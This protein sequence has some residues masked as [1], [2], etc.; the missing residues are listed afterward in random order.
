MKETIKKYLIIYHHEDNDGVFSA[1]IAETYIRMNND[2]PS[3]DNY[4]I[5][6]CPSDYVSLSKIT[7]K[8][9]D[10]WKKKY[11][12]VIMTDISFSDISKMSYMYHKFGNNFI[13]ID[14]HKPAIKASYKNK[15]DAA[16]GERDSN[17]SAILLAFKYFYD[18]INEF[19]NNGKAPKLFRVLSAWDSF[20][21]FKEGFTLEYVRDIN[22]GVT[23][24]FNLNY[25]DVYRFVHTYIHSWL[26]EDDYEDAYNFKTMDSGSLI[27]FKEAGH[28]YNV[29]DDK[30]NESIVMNDGDMSWNVNGRAACALFLQGATNSLMF[31]CVADKVQNGIVF[32][33]KPD[34]NW[35]MSVYNTNIDDKF[36]C[37]EY[38]K[39]KYS[40]GGHAGA[41]GCTLSQDK[42]IEVLTNKSV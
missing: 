4:F 40:G 20:T 7:N 10:N 24:T 19:Y 42:F 21:Y 38:L 32:K 5:D 14:H 36:H 29:Y 34:G 9:I 30:R 31:K 37:G 26:C 16:V 15:Y 18:P 27:K 8:D 25:D 2:W 1:A 11:D 13:W 35:V 41:A 23:E 17:H 12:V 6:K 39:E 3:N 33:H 28:K 22:K